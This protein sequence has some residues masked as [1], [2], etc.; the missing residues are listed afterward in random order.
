MRKSIK[1]I[2]AA[3][4]ACSLAFTLAA[5]LM[6]NTASAA[7]DPIKKAIKMG[8][9][10]VDLDGGTEYHAYFA[11]QSQDSWTFRNSFFE[12]KTGIDNPEVFD[13]MSRSNEDQEIET[14]E[15]TITD[16]VITGNGTY[17]VGVTGLNGA[18][19]E[20]SQLNIL[21][22]STDI[23]YNDTVKFTDIEVK[24]DGVSKATVDEGY[25]N[26]DAE[27]SPK[28]M[29]VN[30]INVWSDELK[31]TAPSIM[32]P[33]DSIE[34]TF[35]VSGFNTDAPASAEETAAAE[36]ETAAV[37]QA[38]SEE[39]TNSGLSTGAVAAIVIVAVVVIAGV[40]VVVKRKKD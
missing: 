37:T 13:T 40:I 20:D 9:K 33:N 15:G 12:K 38:P 30:I 14:V 18:V 31:T 28:T 34:I 3:V 25:L 7:N 11:Y 22:F 21:G 27:E 10:D 24:A 32:C 6:C 2:V 26:P 5:G 1:K 16:A 4:A 17:T 19:V 39:K 29:S 8:K 36:E 35:T 23:P